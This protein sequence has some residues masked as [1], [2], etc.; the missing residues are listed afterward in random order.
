MKGQKRNETLWKPERIPEKNLN[1]FLNTLAPCLLASKKVCSLLDGK[2]YQG[3]GDCQ[4]CDSFEKIQDH[5]LCFHRR[6][7]REK[8]NDVSRHC[9]VSL[10]RDVSWQNSEL[11]CAADCGCLKF[12][13]DWKEWVVYLDLLW[14]SCSEGSCTTSSLGL[15][16]FAPLRR[17]NPNHMELLFQCKGQYMGLL[18]AA[19]LVHRW[20][21]LLWYHPL[22]AVRTT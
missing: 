19:E 22:G 6:E 1:F 9:W 2:R 16:K 12:C 14:S 18:H 20:H 3:I 21:S 8:V 5:G 4:L 17:S 10:R 13:M 11:L 15:P 7:V